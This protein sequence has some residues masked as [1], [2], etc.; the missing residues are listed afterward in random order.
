LLSGM[1]DWP[2]SSFNNS[3]IYRN[4]KLTEKPP[5]WYVLYR[6]EWIWS[7][8]NIFPA[9]QLPASIQMK[10]KWSKWCMVYRTKKYTFQCILSE[11]PESFKN[12][13]PKSHYTDY[14]RLSAENVQFCPSPS[15]DF[16]YS[17]TSFHTSTT[18]LHSCWMA[19]VLNKLNVINTHTHH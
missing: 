10:R 14:R 13:T 11:P 9:L 16:F 19:I 15:T 7:S 4:E 12:S 5:P 2:T 17:L 1:E 6:L 8:R 3:Q 18:L